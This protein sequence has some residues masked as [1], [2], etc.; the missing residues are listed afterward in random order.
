MG[1]SWRYRHDAITPYSI[2]RFTG[3]LV[4]FSWACLYFFTGSNFA[5]M[6]EPVNSL[7]G[8]K[9]R[10]CIKVN[11]KTNQPN[12]P[13]PPFHSIFQPPTTYIQLDPIYYDHDLAVLT[14]NGD[15]ELSLGTN[16]SCRIIK[17]LF[18]LLLTYS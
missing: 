6:D 10:A 17:Y 16:Q 11:R 3:S 12:W 4:R 2:E 13:A 7:L 15:P 5:W 9:L 18:C 14:F 8:E 1:S